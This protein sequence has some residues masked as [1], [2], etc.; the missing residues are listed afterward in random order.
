[1]PQSKVE[2]VRVPTLKT[3]DN[4]RKYTASLGLN[5]PCDDKIETAATS[6]LS[7]P[8]DGVT[9]NGKKIGNRFAVQPMEGWD[10]T[11]TGGLTEEVIRRWSRF[12]ESGAKLICGG[13]AMAV[14]PDGRANPNQLIIREENKAD[15]AK[16]KEILTKAHR[17]R[18]GTIDDLVIG[19][20]LTHSGRFCRPNDKTLESRVAYRHPILD[21]KFYV[22]EDRQVFADSEI[23]GLIGD[24]IKA[25]KIAWEVGADFVDIKHCHGYLLHEFLS[26]FTRPGKY[27]GSFENR[28][29]ILREIV[30]GIRSSGNE[31]EIGVRL[32]AFDTV[33]YKPDPSRAEPGKLGPGI[34]DDFPVPYPYGFG[35]NPQNPL[36]VDLTEAHQF[37]QLCGNLG[38]KILNITGGSPYYCPHIQRPAAYPPSDGYQPPRD[39]LIDVARQIDVTRQVKM[40]APPGLVVIG[41]AY[42]YLQEFLPAVAQA[43]VREGWADM[44]GLGRMILSYPTLPAE[45]LERGALT[46]K[47]IC[48]TFSDC[49]TAP[50][51]GMISGCYPLDKF[52]AAKP[53]AERVKA[54]KKS[55]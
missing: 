46:A 20:Q 6:P 21:K 49:T 34:P 43:V 48:R 31:I 30:E 26:A 28:T 8:I 40:K 7:R 11:R 32:S 51:N 52:Y 19:F 42:S 25:A 16:L 13:E 10:G 27:G 9:I 44:V 12:G 38:I 39:P 50:R 53:E 22:T 23:E 36:E 14:R 35:L 54:L 15:L 1:M 17:E 29:R 55:L 33:P 37:A 2:W 3:P 47:S 41:S 24:Y 45:A 18:F 5:L 4:F